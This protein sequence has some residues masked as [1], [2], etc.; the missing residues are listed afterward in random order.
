MFLF[1]F[2]ISNTILYKIF[3][4]LDVSDNYVYMYVYKYI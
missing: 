4:N 1:N 2:V 3:V